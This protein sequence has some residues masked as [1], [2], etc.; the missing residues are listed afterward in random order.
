[1]FYSLEIS[2]SH[3]TLHKARCTLS[4]K[5]KKP[6]G[7]KRNV[8]ERSNTCIPTWQRTLGQNRTTQYSLKYNF[9]SVCGV[10]QVAHAQN[11][12]NCSFGEGC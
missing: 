8:C 6:T 12:C 7:R 10:W 2:K 3:P 1:M 5:K 9:L 4:P 11:D